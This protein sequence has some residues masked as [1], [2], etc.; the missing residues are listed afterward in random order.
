MRR[1]RRAISFRALSVLALALL[2]VVEVPRPRSVPTK[3]LTKSKAK[4]LILSPGY[5]SALRKLP[6]RSP[7]ADGLARGGRHLDRGNGPPGSTCPGARLADL[8]GITFRAA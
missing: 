1:F 8:D 6:P 4:K 5:H 7:M 2:A 3:N